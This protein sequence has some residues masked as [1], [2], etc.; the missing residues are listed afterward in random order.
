M[1]TCIITSG[2]SFSSSGIPGDGVFKSDAPR[3]YETSPENTEYEND[4]GWID[5]NLHPGKERSWNGHLFRQLNSEIPI[6]AVGKGGVGNDMICQSAMVNLEKH[7]SYKNRIAIIQL[8]GITRKSYY[9][10]PG[11]NLWDF[12]NP[13]ILENA[14]LFSFDWSY[15]VD[16]S[17]ENPSTSKERGWMQATEVDIPGYDHFQNLIFDQHNLTHSFLHNV[18]LLQYYCKSNSIPLFFFFGWKQKFDIEEKDIKHMWDLIDLDNFIC[19]TD[20]IYDGM[21]EW[22]IKNVDEDNRY[23]KYSEED[24]HP[25]DYVHM[26]VAEI[27]KDKIEGYL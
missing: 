27:I 13:Q 16:R 6:Y 10:T 12:I 17:K 20:D 23:N 4:E 14:E 7:K 3:F 9:L 2:C 5:M 11:H 24:L 15:I 25:S 19:L 1:D 26:K 8:S 22:S 21:T 18:L